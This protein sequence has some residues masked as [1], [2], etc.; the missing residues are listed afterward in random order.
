MVDL[1]KPLAY[2]RKME[3][4]SAIE[5]ASMILGGQAKLARALGVTAQSVTKWKRRIPA[6]RVLGIEAATNGYVTRHE[7]RPDLYP[8]STAT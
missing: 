6:E 2:I 5:K 8:E 1:S 7:L 4:I 3:T